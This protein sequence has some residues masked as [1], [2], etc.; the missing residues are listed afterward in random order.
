ML[1]SYQYKLQKEIRDI[2]E[3]LDF[4]LYLFG[5]PKY[6][7]QHDHLYLKESNKFRI[8]KICV[9]LL[10]N[11]CCV[12]SMFSVDVR[13]PNVDDIAQDMSDFANCIMLIFG[14]FYYLLH[15]ISF[16][17]LF[18]VDFFYKQRS[19]DLI[20]EFQ[21]IYRRIGLCNNIDTYI[22]GNW[23][24]QIVN[25]VVEIMLLVIYY[26]FF[27]YGNFTT[28]LFSGLSDYIFIMY[29]I[30]YVSGIRIVVLLKECLDKWIQK[31]LVSQMKQENEEYYLKLF[32][33]YQNIIDAYS[34]YKD[35]YRILVGL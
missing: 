13:R 22:I 17:V 24:S 10:M 16:N 14:I 7:V 19:V 27:S 11:L 23:V 2:V 20:L 8:S 32:R 28:L 33:S 6:C 9:G 29:Y 35:I 34:M 4:G 3:S 30:Y 1:P 15:V 18:I 31:V 26:F 25:I 5:F 21:T 12:Y